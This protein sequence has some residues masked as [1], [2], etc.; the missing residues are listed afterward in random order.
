MGLLITG[1]YNKL[2]IDQTKWYTIDF[3]LLNER[4]VQNEQA[5]K[6]PTVQNEHMDSSKWTSQQSNMDRPLPEI[7][8]KITTK[9]NL[10]NKASSQ[11]NDGCVYV[12]KLTDE[13]KEVYRHFADKYFAWTREIHPNLNKE[14]V[15]KLNYIVEHGCI[16]D[17]ELDRELYIDKDGLIAIIDG[18]FNTQY[19]LDGGGYAD[20]RIWHFLSNGI[21]KNLYY[22]ELY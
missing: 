22:K 20:H 11:A 17:E 16:D 10:N 3:D 2:K 6:T 21:L 13:A 19:K 14:A 9:N 18:Y 5:C 1:N 7:T 12:D 8:S 15:D 4:Y